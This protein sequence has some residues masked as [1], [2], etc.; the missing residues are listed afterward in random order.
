MENFLDSYVNIYNILG[1]E[2]K[3]ALAHAVQKDGIQNSRDAEDPN[4]PEEW[5]VT[6][7]LNL[8]KPCFVSITDTG[9]C[10]LTGRP[11]LDAQT[12]SNLSPK[13][14]RKERWSRFESLG[15]KNP[16]PRARGARG[17]GK[18][19]FVGSSDIGEMIYETL[20]ADG[21][22]RIG[23]WNTNEADPLMNPLEGNQARDYLQKHIPVLEPL[24]NVGTRIVILEPKSELVE[25]FMPLLN[26]DLNRYISETW[27]NLPINGRKIYI[28]HVG[29]KK[30]SVKPPD[31][32]RRFMENPESFKHRIVRDIGIGS[33]RGAK[34]EELVIGYSDKEIPE[35]LQGIAIIRGG[36]KVESF[37]ITHGNEHITPRFRRHIFG[38]IIF[39]E[40][41]ESLL[42]E[43]ESSTHYGFKQTRGSFALIVLGRNGWLKE[44]IRKFA[45][46]ELGLTPESKRRKH[47]ERAHILTLSA[48]NQ[49]ARS[50][51]YSVST[52]VGKDRKIDGKRGPTQKEIR[53]QMPEPSYPNPPLRRI[54]FE[55]E[56]SKIKA[57]AV[58]DSAHSEKLSF[59]FRLK[60]K[61]GYSISGE[62]VIKVFKEDELVLQPKKKTRVFGPYSVVFA[63][64][65]FES[66]MYV[67]EARIF[68]L[69]TSI[70]L[71]ATRHL[72]YLDINP[73]ASGLFKDIQYTEFNPPMN[74]LQYRIERDRDEFILK[75]NTLHPLYQR[76]SKIQ[77]YLV[78]V[79]RSDL[80][81]LDY[82]YVLNLGISALMKEDLV[83]QGKLLE[84][85]L[86]LTEVRNKD[87]ELYEQTLHHGLKLQQELLH[88]AF[89]RFSPKM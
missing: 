35:L 65:N 5:S 78:S 72:V 16:D 62:E 57:W 88:T 86:S 47:K 21:V 79:G 19:I 36:M 23:H 12:L 50:I 13:V 33:F 69:P 89:K 4:N 34:I 63:R 18:F 15:Y 17:Q 40:K 42:K 46:D 53:V 83:D 81:P 60:K 45:E 28:K 41:A 6:F 48:L 37:D 8:H 56:V 66:G 20:R 64:N 87:F 85:E 27:W 39:N 52:T 2:K 51:G 14:Y 10:G 25:A 76:A 61:H 68:S 84:K 7:E 1:I 29:L 73:P 22:Y 67:I 30:I 38:W 70:E 59:E 55:Q 43:T 77:E 11:N 71:D 58:N 75:I 80:R 9:T 24:K 82:D 32:Y 44:Q 74:K 3:S 49:F 31:M 54:E 26:C